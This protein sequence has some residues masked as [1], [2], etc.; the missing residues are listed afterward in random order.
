MAFFT[1][2]LMHKDQLLD[3]F[4]VDGTDGSNIEEVVQHL[5][6]CKFRTCSIL[7]IGVVE[8]R[9]VSMARVRCGVPFVFQHAG[10]A[11]AGAAL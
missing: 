8:K 2:M 5:L 10:A 7:R 4:D 1:A 11:L 6:R 3:A 9:A